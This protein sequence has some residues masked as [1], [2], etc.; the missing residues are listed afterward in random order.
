ML[1]K[2]LAARLHHARIE[3]DGEIAITGIQMDSRLIKPGELFV[4]IP[5][6]AGILEDRHD[7][8]EDAV[9]RGAAA[10]VVEREVQAD[11]RVPRVFVNDARYAL[12]TMA[13]L[14][15]G[16]PSN[17]LKVIGV[18]GTNG[19]TTTSHLIEHILKHRG[20]RTGLMGNI[21]TR[22]GEE[23]KQFANNTQEPP[24]LQRNLLAMADKQ[25]DYCVMEVT[26]QGLHMGR[27]IGTQF[28]T[29]VFTNLTQDHLDYHGTMEAYR[30]AKGL[31][32]S[33]LG[34]AAS[35]DKTFAV[36][37]ADDA[38]SGYFAGLTA[39]QPIT[40]GIGNNADVMAKH[41]R[42]TDEGSDFTVVYR[43]EEMEVH[44][45][46][47]GLFNVYNAL[48]AIAVALIEQLPLAVIAGSLCAMKPVKGR[49]ERLE[50]GQNFTVLI[51]YAHTPDGLEEA[52]KAVTAF[53]RGQVITVFGCGGDRDRDKRP[54]MG[55]IAARYSDRIILTSDNPRYE[56]PD[57]IIKDI[58]TG[59]EQSQFPAAHYEMIADRK[60][61][62]HRAI[63]IA[64]E[65]DVVVI[66]GKGHEAYQLVRG[67]RFDFDDRE[68]ALEAL[69]RLK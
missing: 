19:K 51:D 4:C 65:D 67:Q 48:A 7:Y 9:K 68:A 44:I 63:S 1:L 13:A 35:A 50:A 22:I 60:E 59:L 53:V 64:R 23:E 42:L 15:Y 28:R 49:M 41:I 14:Y 54:Q 29:A 10:L 37:N 6:I 26:S 30:E 21:A 36:L 40:Y 56:H 24:D 55:S 33:R 32:F 52:L 31:L 11:P 25:T 66:A 5:G 16:Y 2:D 57:A 38:A 47:V 8:A 69:R 34:N 43:E 39:A 27:V 58:C 3:G 46:L 61:A 18:T 45:P 62:I 17:C 12:A 20:F